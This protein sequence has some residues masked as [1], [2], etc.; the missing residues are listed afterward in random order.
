MAEA[1]AQ[2]LG[3]GDAITD[4]DRWVWR[5]AFRI[6]SGEMKRRSQGRPLEDD[7]SYEMPEPP[8][9]L[10][11]VLRLLSLKQR[12]V[13]ILHFYAGHSTR[14]V[15]SI[16]GS[17]TGTVRVHISQGRKRLRQSCWSW[18]MPDF[19]ERLGE[20]GSIEPPDV[21]SEVERL[22]PKAPIESGPSPLRRAG[23]AIV[24]LAVAL[25]GYVLV[26]RAF[27]GPAVLPGA[28]QSPTI[29]AG[30]AGNGLIAFDCGYHI[31]TVAA[32]GSGLTDLI[33]PHD[34]DVV[35]AAYSPMFSPDGSKIAFRG[36]PKGATSGGANY[37]IYV[38]NAEGSG[39]T[40]LT[41]SQSDVSERLVAVVHA[42]V[43]R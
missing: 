4:Q 5:A 12:A 27:N 39:V 11:R 33:E 15:A 14:E 20:L 21:W 32:D 42:M 19:L 17:T 41:T 24:A 7:R 9:D 26:D 1:F 36:Y 18:K 6:A 8:I 13:I 25:A 3:R 35:L 10:I 29:S 22:G 16:L 2:A 38:M 43:A 30:P 23:V 31:C 40:N 34:E 37:D 28:S